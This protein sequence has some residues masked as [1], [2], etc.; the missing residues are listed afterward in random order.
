MRLIIKISLIQQLDLHWIVG[1]L[2][3]QRVEL[4]DWLWL[5]KNTMIQHRGL[6]KG[7]KNTNLFVEKWFFPLLLN[8]AWPGWST[9]WLDRSEFIKRPAVATALPN[10][11]DPAGRPGTQVTRANPDETQFFFFF[12]CGIWNPLVYILY[13][14]MKKTMFFQCG[15]KTFWFKYFN[16][17]G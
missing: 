7:Q 9:R 8:P 11:G 14:P 6:Y 17:K 12:K 10:S 3:D 2:V 13:V 4:I 16:L 5:K 15:I 1:H